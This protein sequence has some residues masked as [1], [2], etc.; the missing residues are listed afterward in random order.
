MVSS[1]FAIIIL[2]LARQSA[3]NGESTAEAMELNVAQAAYCV[4]L[5]C[6]GDT[7]V[8]ARPEIL[9][10]DYACD[11]DKCKPELCKNWKTAKCRKDCYCKKCKDTLEVN[12]YRCV[13]FKEDA[14]NDDCDCA[15]Q[16]QE[17][18]CKTQTTVIS[19]ASEKFDS[20]KKDAQD[21]AEKFAKAAAYPQ[22]CFTRCYCNKCFEKFS[23]KM[24]ETCDENRKIS[25]TD[26]LC[27]ELDP[28]LQC[29]S[30]ENLEQLKKLEPEYEKIKNEAFEE[31]AKELEGWEDQL[32]EA[33]RLAKDVKNPENRKK[34]EKARCDLT[35]FCRSCK[36]KIP[37]IAKDKCAGFEAASDCECDEDL[38]CKD[39]E[40][41]VECNMKCICDTCTSQRENLVKYKIDSFEKSC[42]LYEAGGSKSHIKNCQ[43]EDREVDCKILDLPKNLQKDEL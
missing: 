1:Y 27:S 25:V 30:Q 35:C 2:A 23:N 38:D 19:D 33:R 32:K 10:S 43:C 31:A 18:E 37:E 39:I 20:L 12:D 34:M 17:I 21:I 36:E 11:M 4:C 3:V 22:E 41:E 14:V 6:E 15:A 42:G 9:P 13:T 28:I 29:P 40:T 24:K 8:C 5:C 16:D 7:G 26:C